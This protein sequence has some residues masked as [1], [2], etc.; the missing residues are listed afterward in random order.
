MITAL[1]ISVPV[2]PVME[3]IK[4]KLEQDMELQQRSIISVHH[5]IQL[6]GLCLYNIF[7]V[8]GTVLQAGRGV[9]IGSTVSPIVFNLYMEDF[10][11]R[12]LTM[13]KMWL[14]VL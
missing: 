6:L 8:P 2:G 11:A 5:S 1:F 9:A 7:P 10:K 14:T 13:E 12:P 4:H 3:T